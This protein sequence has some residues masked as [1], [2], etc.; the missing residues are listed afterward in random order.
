MG[1]PATIESSV[2]LGTTTH[3]FL[4]L[5]NGEEIEAVQDAEDWEILPNGQEVTLTIN[6]TK[7]NLFDE[8]GNTP[9]IIREED[10]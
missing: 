10:R 5:K 1:I 6:T 3:Y 2:F 8:E 7:V 4:K 9:F